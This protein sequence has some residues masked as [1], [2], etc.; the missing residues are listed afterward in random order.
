MNKRYM[1]R[2]EEDR[3]SFNTLRYITRVRP[4]LINREDW[5]I[6]PFVYDTMCNTLG[7]NIVEEFGE[8]TRSYYTLEG[9][10]NNL[11]KYDRAILSKPN[12]H[13]LHLAIAK[14][15][16]EFKLDA[17]VHAYSFNELASVP[18]ISSSSAGWNLVGKKG[19]PGNH[20]RAIHH[21]VLS[22]NMWLEDRIYGT[23][24]FRFHPDLAWTRTQ[25]GTVEDPKIRN[26]W[27]T[28]F[29]NIILEGT[30][31]YP[32]IQAYRRKGTPMAV[33]MNYYKRLPSMIHSCLYENEILQVRSSVRRSSV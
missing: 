8:Y 22:I 6:D 12:D 27:G 28:S 11:W 30:S 25:L 33:G 2:N 4:H 14:T 3:P 17:P 20:E 24:N 29:G 5:L 9:H 19:D 21:A 23:S 16:S 15:R 10:Y 7:V 13:N 1:M 31:A 32:L 26:V 18:F